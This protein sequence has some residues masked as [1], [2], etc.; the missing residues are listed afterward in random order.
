[1]NR[2]L[3]LMAVS[4]ALLAFAMAFAACGDD[5][6]DDD[7]GDASGTPAATTPAAND[8]EVQALIETIEKLA[9]Q[10]GAGIS[11][12]DAEYYLAHVTDTFLQGFGTESKAACE[13]DIEA[14]VGEP[15]PNATV[16][17]DDV[18]ID[19]DTARVVVQS[20]IG[21]FGLIATKEGDEWLADGQFV[22]ND[23]IPEGVEVIEFEMAEFAFPSDLSSDAISS[24]NFALHAKNI[25]Q[26]THEIIL[27]PLPAEGT[28]EELL[29]DE[30]F[31]PEPIFV[32]VPYEPGD[33]SDIALPEP[34][35][36]GRYAFVCF[37]P[38]TED[39]EGT[40]HAFKGMTREFTVE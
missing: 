12:A 24:G 33:E 2:K 9:N 30:S 1:M 23:E 16:S 35:E 5:D 22:P 15:L 10:Q 29:A 6:D 32:K 4:V 25:G 8:E 14:C 38:D 36:P 37:L 13:A 26:Q 31:Q 40:P 39:A 3:W 17:E 19:G 21:S 27:A 18:E 28:I 20:D 34:L 7:G 11:D